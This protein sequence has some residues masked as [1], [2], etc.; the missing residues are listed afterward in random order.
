MALRDGLTVTWDHGVRHIIYDS[1]CKDPVSILQVSTRI[2]THVH[3]SVLREISDLLARPWR[4]ELSWCGREANYVADWLAKR[5]AVVSTAG[6]TLIE[7][8]SPELEVLLLRD[9]L[10]IS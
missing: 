3:A 9:S 8:Q 7:V 5:G 2:S 10:W 1:D 6:C 4:V